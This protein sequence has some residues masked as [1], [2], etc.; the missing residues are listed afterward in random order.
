M[1]GMIHIEKPKK[2]TPKA[3]KGQAK[4]AAPAGTADTSTAG[5]VGASSES[6]FSQYHYHKLT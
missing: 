4:V 1:E 6:K 5:E 3:K 2:K